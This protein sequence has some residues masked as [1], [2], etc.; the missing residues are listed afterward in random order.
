MILEKGY[1]SQVLEGGKL[2]KIV[3]ADNSIIE[4]LLL[5]SYGEN[6]NIEPDNNSL[7]LVIGQSTDNA[8]AIPFNIATQSILEATEKAVGNFKKGNKIT[9]K[10]NGDIEITGTETLLAIIAT[11]FKVNA[12]LIELADATAEVLNKNASMQ[13]V[14]PSGSSAG[15]YQVDIINAGQTKVKA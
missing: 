11:K 10:K 2:A 13:V 8:M 9:F 6:S 5:Y 4:C 1:I 15:T 12:P 7:A 3:L 14:I